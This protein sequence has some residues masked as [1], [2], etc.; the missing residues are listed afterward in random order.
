M[1]PI[2]LLPAHTATVPRGVPLQRLRVLFA[3]IVRDMNAK[4]G[5]SVGGYLWA[6]AEPLGGI[7]LLAVAFSLALR[8]PPI[9]T[10]FLFFY[11]TGIIPFT[12]YGSIAPAPRAR[13]ATT[14]A[15]S[16]IRWSP[17]SMRSSPGRSSSS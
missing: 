1:P 12:L 8:T 14:A 10:S 5:R 17:R 4:F 16:A 2:P 7:V 15:C 9:G 13:C 3:L 6:V 11:A